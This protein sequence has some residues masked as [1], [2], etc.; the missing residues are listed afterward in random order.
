MNVLAKYDLTADLES[1][2]CKGIQLFSSTEMCALELYQVQASRQAGRP[3]DL[4]L[5][6]IY[7]TQLANAGMTSCNHHPLAPSLPFSQKNRHAVSLWK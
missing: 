5:I 4:F 2:C 1:D 3:R 7:H 6:Q